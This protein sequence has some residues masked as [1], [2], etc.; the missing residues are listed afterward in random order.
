MILAMLRKEPLV[1]VTNQNDC[2]NS[3]QQQSKASDGDGSVTGEKKRCGQNFKRLTFSKC[4]N[5]SFLKIGT[6]P[7]NGYD[8]IG[9]IMTMW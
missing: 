2:V 9:S 5:N 6:N 3:E 4:K 1:Y 8:F 7:F